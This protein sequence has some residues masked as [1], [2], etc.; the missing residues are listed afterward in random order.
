MDGLIL[1]INRGLQPVGRKRKKYIEKAYKLLPRLHN[2]SILDIGCG[3]G[4]PTIKLARLS[5][6]SVIGIDIDEQDIDQFRTTIRR[7]HLSP[8]VK[9]L[10]MSMYDIDFNEE[11]FDIVWSEGSIYAIGFERGLKEWKRLIK[12]NGFLVI[13]EMVWTQDN[14]PDEIKRYWKSMYPGITTVD[15][16]IRIIKKENYELLHSFLLPDNVWYEEYYIPLEKRLSILRKKYLGNQRALQMIKDKQEEI[17]MYR[18]Y[19]AVY[20]SV[21]FIMQKKE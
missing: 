11:S 9:A 19:S 18:K 4:K 21:Y 10:N 13:H 14:P 8:R 17:N 7:L 5:K 15:N 12:P 3:S 1:E 20:G 2:P 16:N 6:G